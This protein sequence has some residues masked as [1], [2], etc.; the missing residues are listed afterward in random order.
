MKEN[1]IKSKRREL[2]ITQE[3]LARIVEVS[4]K[5]IYNIENGKQDTTLEIAH[6]IKK[7]LK[8]K[9]LDELFPE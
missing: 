1:N 2:K 3:E 4:N 7:V 9:T 5:T 6:K 8:C